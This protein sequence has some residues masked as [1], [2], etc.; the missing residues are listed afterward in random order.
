MQTYRGFPTERLSQPVY[1]TIGN[2]D[3]VHR[4]HRMLVAEL[5]S[6]ARSEGAL[7]GLLTFEPHPLTVLRPDLRIARLTSNEEREHALSALGLDFSLILP[8]DEI[9]AS[10]SAVDFMRSL[11]QAIPLRV[12]WVGP[13]F[14][15]G[16]GREGNAEALNRIGAEL[17]F[18]VRVVPLLAWQG[19]PVRSSRVRA[20][21][22]EEGAVAEAAELLGRPY[23]IWGTVTSGAQRGR[24]LGFPTANLDVPADRLLPAHGV[25]ACWAWRGDAG[26]P[27]VV[28]IGVRPS[29]GSGVASVEAH[30]L[31]FDGDLYGETLGLSFIAWMRPESR[32]RSI[33]DLAAQ[34]HSDAQAGRRI[35]ADPPTHADR[36]GDRPWCE[37]DH[38][39]DLAVQVEGADPRA[40]FANAAAAMYEIQ[41]ADR[42]RPIAVARAIDTSADGWSEL[43]V[44]W[45]NRLLL[46]QEVAG[47]MY[48]RFEIF[49][50]SS[51]GMRG[52]AY[53][54]RGSP[55]HTAVKATTHYDLAVAQSDRGWQAKVTFDV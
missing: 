25:Y 4:G 44:N 49:E 43:L 30:L 19:E 52:V 23:Q 10:T 2:F 18:E 34:I 13:D 50:M 53:G 48:T 29:F 7:A 38:T 14:A 51:R 36:F 3:G 27:A 6:A 33:T 16:R 40:L 55:H 21:L 12:L 17:G 41:E 22:S 54:Y 32:F 37:I 42:S 28:N 45:L 35:L 31:E 26:Y 46:N 8:F 20:L 9:S 1:L 5:S 11:V 47:E 24:E 15:L 39:A